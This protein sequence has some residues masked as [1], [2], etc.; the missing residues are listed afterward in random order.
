MKYKNRSY[1]ESVTKALALGYR[2]V[3][4]NGAYKGSYFVKNGKVWIFNLEGLAKHL[5]ATCHHDF[6]K[7]HYAI[8]DYLLYNHLSLEETIRTVFGENSTQ[9]AEFCAEYESKEHFS[10]YYDRGDSISGGCSFADLYDFSGG[11][12]CG[13]AYLGDGLWIT[14]SG[15]LRD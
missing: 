7:H 2:K 8:E 15:S 1:H 6:T 4:K 11:D 3:R 10:D 14:S 12:G 13:D 5:N 9:Y